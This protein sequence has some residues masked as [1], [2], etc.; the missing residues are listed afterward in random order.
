MKREGPNPLDIQGDVLKAY[1]LPVSAHVFV[2]ISDSIGGQAVLAATLAQVTSAADWTNRPA[3]TLNVGISSTGLQALGAPHELIDSFPDAFRQGMAARSSLL[4]DT[5]RSAPSTWEGGLGTGEAH[6]LFTINAA[7]ARQLDDAVDQLVEICAANDVTV[8]SDQRGARLPDRKE[9]FGYTDG[10]G[11]PAVDGTDDPVKGEGDLTL[12]HQWRGLPVGEFFHG[13]IDGDGHPSPGPA[14]PFERDGT[15]KVW[16]KLHE[17]VP[18]FRQWVA[19]ESTRLGFDDE[20]LRA[21]LIGRW[22]DGTPLALSP[23]RPDPAI[24]ADPGR[25]NDFDYTKD[26]RGDRCPLGAHIRRVNPRAGLGFGD[27]L[28]ERQRIIRR[29]MTYGPALAEGAPADGADRGI[30]FVAY[31]ADIERQYEFIQ[32]NW[33]NSGDVVGVGRDRDP[34]VGRAPG[35]HKFVVPGPMPAIVHPLP[36]LVTTKG[37]EYLWVPSVPS[38][39]RL[40]N[41]NYDAD[42]VVPAVSLPERLVG[43]ALG[44]ALVPVAAAGSLVRGKRIVHPVGVGYEA[45]LE[46]FDPPL[47]LLAGTGLAEPGRFPA[48]VRLSRAFALPGQRRDVR[49]F[50]LRLAEVGAPEAVQDLLLAT[51]APGRLGNAVSVLL[52]SYDGTYST[53]VRLRA[54]NGPLLF[55]V[56]TRQAMPSD[57]DIEAG[58]GVGLRF[59]VSAGPSADELRILGIVRLLAPLTNAETEALSFSL[60][61]DGAGLRAGGI[62]NAARKIAYRSS[63]RGRS[64]R[65]SSTRSLR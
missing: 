61:N 53:M 8:V 4:G 64:L 49:G 45:E 34:F 2:T 36:E 62:L 54:P 40:A 19:A 56:R 59:D 1:G 12:L 51:V 23:D 14:P 16:R 3:V 44:V 55:H 24:A 46:V 27:S 18:V 15:F 57:P 6:I 5:G 37:G 43:G 63:H 42:P 26:P 13:H 35:D 60:A 50:A 25:F 32:S 39:E 11:Q 17:D 7:S 10:I 48:V 38:L 33:C 30:Y 20:L 52:E 31:M 41:G 29:G 47:P 65:R 21:K 9:H 22:P 28:S 58:S